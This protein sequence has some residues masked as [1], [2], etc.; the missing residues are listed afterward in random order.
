[1]TLQAFE[2]C[3]NKYDWGA[4]LRI[5]LYYVMRTGKRTNF[6]DVGSLATISSES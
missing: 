3:D 2:K 6:C 5:G 4:Y 1:M